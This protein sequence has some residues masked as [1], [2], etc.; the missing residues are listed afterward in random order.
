MILQTIGTRNRDPFGIDARPPILEGIGMTRKEEGVL[1]G[2]EAHM[3]QFGDA[4]DVIQ[5]VL[6]IMSCLLFS[7]FFSLFRARLN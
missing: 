4:R 1:D 2:V 3:G 7:F 5:R 6:Y